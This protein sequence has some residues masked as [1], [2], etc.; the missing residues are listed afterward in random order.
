MNGNAWIH[1]HG[2]LTSLVRGTLNERFFLFVWLP[3]DIAASAFEFP[4]VDGR[5]SP[6]LKFNSKQ[7][8]YKSF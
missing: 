6:D 7:I 2:C 5:G 3:R 8:L 1:F 4:C